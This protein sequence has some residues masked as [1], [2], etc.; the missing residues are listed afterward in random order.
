MTEICKQYDLIMFNQ[1]TEKQQLNIIPEEY[2]EYESKGCGIGHTTNTIE[3]K[4]ICCF[5]L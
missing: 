4:R 5:F 2:T 1:L 3:L